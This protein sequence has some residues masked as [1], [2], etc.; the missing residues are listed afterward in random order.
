MSERSPFRRV[1]VKQAKT[2]DIES[3]FKD[4]KGRSPNIRD[5]YSQQ[6]DVLRI[7]QDKHLTSKDVSIE[8]PTGSGKTLVGLLI[9]EYRRK[10]LGERVL[11]LCPTRQL[12][13]QVGNQSEDYA[14]PTRVLVGPKR[15]FNRRDIQLYRSARATA[16][17]TYSGLFNTNPEFNDPQTI[18]LDDAHGGESYISSLWSLTVR[19]TEAPELYMKILSLFEKD[20]PS[21]LASVLNG[22]TRPSPIPK[23]E[24]IPF[25][26]FH[27]EIDQLREVLNASLP[28]PE[29]SDLFFSWQTVRDG[30]QACHA[31]ITWDQVTI[32]PYIPPT[33]THRPFAEAN[34]RIYMS[35]TLGS[36][37][38]LER[39][40]G[41]RSI[42]RVPIPRTYLK[43]GIGRRFFI[44][45]DLI[46]S[47]GGVESW[48]AKTMSQSGRTLGLCPTGDSVQTL[49]KI[50][51]LSSPSPKILG[52]RDIE[53]SLKLFSSSKSVLLA[54]ANRYDGIDISSRDCKLLVVYGLPSG[55]NLQEAFLEEKLGLDVLLR[56]RIKTRISQAA[57]RCTRSDTDSAAVI[58]VGRRLL[59]FCT[60]HE[61]Q[62]LFNAELRA[63][64]QFSLDQEAKDFSRTDAMLGSFLAR[65]ENWDDAEQD[66]VTLREADIR[67]DSKLTE[68]LA[69]VAAEEVDFC[70]DLWA[71]NFKNATKHGNAV[72]D[73]LADSRLSVYRAL[74]FYFT[75]N[76]AYATSKE[77]REYGKVSEK[78]MSRAIQTCRTVSW[79]AGALRSMLPA[80]KLRSV[81]TGLETIATEGIADVLQDLGSTGPGFSRKMTEVGGLLKQ[82][83]SSKFDRG[84]AELGKLLGFSSWKPGSQ[85]AP[86]CV[87]QL[88]NDLALLFEGKSEES[89]EGPVSVEDCRQAS[90]H[91]KWASS[92]QGLKGC[93]SVLSI[94]VTPRSSLDKNALP[95]AKDLYLTKPSDL[96]RIFERA[97]A[98]LMTVR[99]AMT[100]EMDE[101]FKERI[102][103][104]LVSTELTPNSIQ[105][106]L[107]S[108]HA[109]APIGR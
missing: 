52:A 66:I 18:I 102:L 101:E 82:K 41:V 4:L 15:E 6:A 79:F 67:S 14:I 97:Q 48:L 37:G 90:G 5:L 99:S 83:E 11:Y 51:R 13:H 60:K 78:L 35:A 89:P 54:L 36:G 40:T 10:T 106:L 29:V 7:Y 9:A 23:P 25:G 104:E 62:A 100:D 12:A 96:W 49:V 22:T 75:A 63:E 91:L 65:D 92:E 3:L 31:Y 8:L 1:G 85:A 39:T 59:N 17:S 33:M 20:I 68:M 46:D 28:S 26:A 56:E 86:D 84:M 109:L 107:T 2:E 53:D 73:G 57:G 16:V 76:A 24:L 30:L 61:N 93:K 38:E 27:R 87:W 70:Y 34:Q 105:E 44:F 98:M 80:E 69:E 95:H 71:G 42:E 94:L 108:R 45:P 64:I 88:G 58:M 50:S 81:A 21:N 32:R 72:T 55:T 19:R 103:S 74:W 47:S 43:R 77:D